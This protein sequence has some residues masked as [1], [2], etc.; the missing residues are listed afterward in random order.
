[1]GS[2]SRRRPTVAVPA[3]S[4]AR[5]RRWASVTVVI[6]LV[7]A[8]QALLEA[9]VTDSAAVADSATAAV[10]RATELF[11]STERESREGAVALLRSAA[12]QYLR[13]G[14]RNGQAEAIRS[15]GTVLNALGHPDSALLQYASSLDIYRQTGNR[16]G[17][18]ATL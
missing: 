16:S 1:M 7:G 2:S 6:A 5:L 10:V 14:D 9:Q 11:R 12:A 8:R 13:A 17:E 3:R 18:A 15:A 4:D